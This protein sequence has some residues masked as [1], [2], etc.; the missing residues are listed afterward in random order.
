MDWRWVTYK[1]LEHGAWKRSLV[2]EPFYISTDDRYSRW[3]V[4]NGKDGKLRMR[5]GAD[6]IPPRRL[7]E[8]NW[9]EG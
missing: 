4:L 7:Y 9:K 2:F 6:W 8:I 5:C 1:K 3:V